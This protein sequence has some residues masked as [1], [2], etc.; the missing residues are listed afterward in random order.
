MLRVSIAS[1]RV[2]KG[3]YFDNMTVILWVMLSKGAIF[4]KVQINAE[5]RILA[6]ENPKY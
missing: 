3:G 6:G 1:F 2:S 4:D 5:K